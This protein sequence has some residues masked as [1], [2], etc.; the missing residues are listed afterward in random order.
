MA[1]Y[2]G[3]LAG[4]ST[5]ICQIRQIWRY[6]RKSLKTKGMASGWAAGAADRRYV[7]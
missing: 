3:R 7:D 5:L 2:P 6:F 4:R 1:K